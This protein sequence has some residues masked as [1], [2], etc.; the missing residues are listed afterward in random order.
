MARWA[1]DLSAVHPA[2][3]TQERVGRVDLGTTY[4][5]SLPTPQ[6]EDSISVMPPI[7][8]SPLTPETDGPKLGVGATK[9]LGT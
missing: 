4:S 8:S 7:P 9:E 1:A 6:G 5:L 3:P 2:L